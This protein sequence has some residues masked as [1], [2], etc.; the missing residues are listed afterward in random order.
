ML[1]ER[2]GPCM[3]RSRPVKAVSIFS[4]FRCCR[5]IFAL[6]SVVWVSLYFKELWPGGIC[7][8]FVVLSG[9]L[10]AYIMNILH[11]YCC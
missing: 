8:V 2:V 4:V 1:G 9:S 5:W 11:S 3:T 7:Q 10:A 6:L